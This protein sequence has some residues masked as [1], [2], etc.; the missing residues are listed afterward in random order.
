MPAKRVLLQFRPS[1]PSESY[2]RSELIVES[3]TRHEY[4]AEFM[5]LTRD[6][7]LRF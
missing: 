1:S 2:E 7:Y 5:Q 6:F 3:E 4:S